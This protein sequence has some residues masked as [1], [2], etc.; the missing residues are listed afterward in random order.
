[1][2][3]PLCRHEDVIDVVGLGHV[4]CPKERWVWLLALAYIEEVVIDANEAE[5]S[6]RV[7]RSTVVWSSLRIPIDAVIEIPEHQ[8]RTRLDEW[9]PSVDHLMEAQTRWLPS[10]T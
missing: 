1:M 2:V 6:E 5:V 8:R 7:D 10:R 9:C 3:P 4:V